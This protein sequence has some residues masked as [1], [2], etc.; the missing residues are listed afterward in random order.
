MQWAARVVGGGAV[1]FGQMIDDGQGVADWE[2]VKV[3]EGELGFPILN[4]RFTSGCLRSRITLDMGVRPNIRS[5]PL[6]LPSPRRTGRGWPKA[7]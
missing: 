2:E 3:G 4:F 7:G 1:L 6:T 5:R